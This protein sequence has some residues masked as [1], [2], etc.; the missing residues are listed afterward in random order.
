MTATLTNKADF[1]SIKFQAH[2]LQSTESKAG[3][4]LGRR[5]AISPSE[6]RKRGLKCPWNQN[7][8]LSK[9]HK[10]YIAPLSFW[11]SSSV[12]SLANF[13][14]R[15]NNVVGGA[16][17]VPTNQPCRPSNLG[18]TEK[19]ADSYFIDSSWEFHWT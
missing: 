7:N 15:L 18:A 19:V 3:G 16:R 4:L 1:A 10:C 6:V 17:K 14:R 13:P 5:K 12:V 8:G 11:L 2:K 9:L